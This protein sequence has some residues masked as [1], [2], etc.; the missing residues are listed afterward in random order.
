MSG[1]TS[2]AGI[3]ITDVTTTQQAPLGFQMTVPSAN[4]SNS[5]YT[6][7]RAGTNII[8]GVCAA[9]ASASSPTGDAG[10]GAAA[11]GVGTMSNTRY[12]GVAQVDIPNTFYGFVLTRGV[13]L[14]KVNSESVAAD[15]LV[16]H[17]SGGE[18]DDAAASAT[19]TVV[20]H[21]LGDTIAAGAVGN[22]YVHFAG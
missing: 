21:V 16:V 5:V 10:Y 8:T 11:L 1:F 6:Y 7:I 20:G 4:N 22:V 3:S 19:N 18:L 12:I 14:A 13:G 17:S 2:A 15:A 9:T